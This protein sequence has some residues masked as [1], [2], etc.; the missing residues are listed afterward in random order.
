MVTKG[1]PRVMVYGTLKKGHGNHKHFFGNSKS[2]TFLGNCTIEGEF[3]MLNI[4]GTLPGVIDLEEA[5][6]EL[7]KKFTGGA[8]HGEV[9]AITPELLTSIDHLEGHPS[10]Y[11]RKQI[12]TPWKNT[13]CY[14]LPSYWLDVREAEDNI[15]SP[16]NWGGPTA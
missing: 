5:R 15:I 16:A 10:F 9:Y 14:F 11:K 12:K 2:S 13:W 3:V 1:L 6:P 4:Y 8:L 7:K